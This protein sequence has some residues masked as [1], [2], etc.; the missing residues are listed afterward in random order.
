MTKQ[1]RRL[2][3]LLASVVLIV[4]V[5]RCAPLFGVTPEW[6]NVSGSD[7]ADASGVIAADEVAVSS[8]YGGKIA[9]LYVAEGDAV[10]AGQE[11]LMLDAV[12]LEAQIAVARAQLEVAQASLR[13]L[14]AG[15]RPGVVA[16]AE[17]RL[18]QAK[19]A[20]QAAEQGLADAQTLRDN[21]QQLDM[22]IAVGE[23]QVE[24]AQHRLDSAVALK[25]AAETGKNLAEYTLDVIRNWH[26]PVPPPKLPA[27]LQSATYDWWKGWTGVNAAS[28]ALQDAQARLAYWRSVR[29]NPQQLNAQVEAAKAALQQAQAGVQAAQAQLD[30]YKA[31]ASAEQ[32]AAAQARVAQAQAALDALLIQRKEMVVLAPQDG[33][34][35]SLVVHASEIAAPG[36]TLLTLANLTEVKLNVYVAE[37]HLGQI[38]L[39][40]KVSV[41]VDSFPGRSFEGHIVHISDRP[42]YTPRNVATKEQRVNTVYAVEIRVPNSEGLLKP[43]MA[44]DVTFLR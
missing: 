16:V 39:G 34:I 18:E 13:Q 15:A 3:G 4:A 14:E 38:A 44:A 42:Q 9:A 29:E 20:Q 35:L 40:Q 22:Q 30:G 8:T 24:A 32:L 43:G 11:L 37:N 26:Y 27:E 36:A 6:L 1:M 5:V 21:P 2:L 33:L 23:A 12:L 7:K 41:M 31:G 19:A 28:A 25:D 17:A 10:K